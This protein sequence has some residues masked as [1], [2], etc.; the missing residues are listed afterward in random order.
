[1]ARLDDLA[2][3][4]AVDTLAAVA[5]SGDE[6]II[7]KVS[8]AVGDTSATLQEAFLTAV[9]IKSA[10]DRGHQTLKAL[11]RGEKID[12]LDNPNL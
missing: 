10:S 4:L 11:I 7:E 2:E 8:K 1:M 5:R 9:R 3:K 12:T 6:A